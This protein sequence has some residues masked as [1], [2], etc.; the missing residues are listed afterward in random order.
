VRAALSGLRK[1]GGVTYITG[2]A[3]LA[4][5]IF[6]GNSSGYAL[7]VLHEGLRERDPLGLITVREVPDPGVDALADVLVSLPGRVSE[8]AGI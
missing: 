5:P 3:T 7:G 2:V 4:K 8:E 1:L 6:M